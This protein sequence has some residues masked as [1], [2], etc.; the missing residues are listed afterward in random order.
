MLETN[1]VE[2]PYYVI[3]HLVTW[4]HSI[5]ALAASEYCSPLIIDMPLSFAMSQL[6]SVKN[7]NYKI[8]NELSSTTVAL[9][10]HILGIQCQDDICEGNSN[11]QNETLK[12]QI[13]G[14]AR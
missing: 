10:H 13:Q 5:C 6:F 8:A 12:M 2:V 4:C 3:R 14:Y 1:E 11:R 9:Q 7:E